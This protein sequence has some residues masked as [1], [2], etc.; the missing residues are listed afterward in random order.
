MK[1][2]KLNFLAQS[3]QFYF[4]IKLYKHIFVAKYFQKINSQYFLK[5]E[6]KN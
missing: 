6:S 3:I 4:L 1:K 5:K 2:E